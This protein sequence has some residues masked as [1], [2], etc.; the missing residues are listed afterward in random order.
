MRYNL[1]FEQGRYEEA[2]EGFLRLLDDPHGQPMHANVAYCYRALGQH[3]QAVRHFEAYLEELPFKQHAW[4]ALAYSFYELKDYEGMTKSAREAIKWDVQKGVRDDYP[5]QQLATAHFLL[6]DLST[7]L[8]AARKAS[9][10][11][12][13]N[14]FS[15]YYEA[16]ALYA[17]SEGAELDEPSLIEGLEGLELRA[18]ATSR[19]AQSFKLKPEL[20]EE[21]RE[22]GHVSALID[23]ALA[24]T[25]S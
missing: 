24:L 5:W 19:L 20:V 25:L 21:A 9:E 8:M 2:L 14:A 13:R 1:L 22:E 17:I 4:K 6:G 11:N 10:L 16:C 3:E 18:E 15:L 12:P 7:S 23:E